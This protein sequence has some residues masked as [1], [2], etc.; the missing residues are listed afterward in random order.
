MS[1]R[2]KKD[3]NNWPG[4]LIWIRGENPCHESVEHGNDSRVNGLAVLMASKDGW[5][6]QSPSASLFVH[7][8]HLVF[9]I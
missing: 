4:Y 7:D 8:K 5:R 6:I 3:D 9:K 2:K 1:V